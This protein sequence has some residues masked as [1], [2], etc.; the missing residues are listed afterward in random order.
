MASGLLLISDRIP[1]A[2]QSR[3][4]RVWF[5]PL[6]SAEAFRLLERETPSASIDPEDEPLARLV[7]RGLPAKAIAHELG[8]TTRSLYRRLARLRLHLE[9]GSIP[10]LVATLAAAGYGTRKGDK[11]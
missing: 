11:D 1:A 2:W 8:L 4:L 3:A 6:G 10:E 5:V 9:A 7:A